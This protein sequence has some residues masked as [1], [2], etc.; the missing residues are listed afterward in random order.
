MA[1]MACPG[2]K[3]VGM[4]A[5]AGDAAALIDYLMA[6]DFAA[7]PIGLSLFLRLCTA[8]VRITAAAMK[9]ICAQPYAPVLDTMN[10]VRAV[11]GRYVKLALADD[12]FDGSP[13][14]DPMVKGRIW[15][16]VR[17]LSPRLWG[18]DL[19]IFGRESATRAKAVDELS[20]TELGLCL[21]DMLF[22]L[23]RFWT[24]VVS[25]ED[26]RRLQSIVFAFPYDTYGDVAAL[27]QAVVTPILDRMLSRPLRR[28]RARDFS[29][30]RKPGRQLPE[31][32]CV[33]PLRDVLAAKIFKTECPDEHDWYRQARRA[34]ES[35]LACPAP[36]LIT[37]KHVV[38]TK[39]PS[40]G[41]GT[42]GGSGDPAAGPT[43][44][45]D[46]DMKKQLAKARLEERDKATKNQKE[47]LR[48]QKRELE[49]KADKRVA[50]ARNDTDKRRRSRSRSRDR[51]NRRR[52]SKTRSR[53]R[54]HDRNN[55]DDTGSAGKTA[56]LSTFLTEWNKFCV[57]EGIVAP[58]APPVMMPCARTV[59]LKK[60]NP[61]PGNICGY[62]HDVTI[63]ALVTTDK[64]CKFISLFCAAFGRMPGV[65][66]TQLL[67]QYASARPYTITTRPKGAPRGRYFGSRNQRGGGG[68]GWDN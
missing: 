32:Q 36:L 55:Q 53:S 16:L 54:S 52:R 45:S 38:H 12:R 48:K 2:V 33:V 39:S 14:D 66:S 23:A 8:K 6:L 51:D 24:C 3:Q 31:E 68:R 59:L 17:L 42:A 21:T 43:P 5:A 13:F 65:F 22:V 40:L 67:P 50:D 19:P 30:V 58:N 35:G 64:A 62:G 47:A 61:A 4:L 44:R 18:A 56:S 10:T 57:A 63:A 7:G 46:A 1:M 49:L 26:G 37:A 28:L 20:K 9:L 25:E 27:R 41:G 34:S 11:V 60:C 15:Q 29:S